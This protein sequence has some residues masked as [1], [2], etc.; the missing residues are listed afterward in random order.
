MITVSDNDQSKDGQELRRHDRGGTS[1]TR[2]GCEGE[3]SGR[4]GCVA[5]SMEPRFGKCYRQCRLAKGYKGQGLDCR[6][7]EEEAEGALSAQENRLS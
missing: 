6:H 1:G 2:Q 3:G 7:G 5:L 4:T